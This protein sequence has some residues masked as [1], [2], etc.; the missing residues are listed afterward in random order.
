[1]RLRGDGTLKGVLWVLAEGADPYTGE[2]WPSYQTIADDAE[3]HRDTA[4]R[5]VK[6]AV[7][8]GLVTVLEQDFRS[9]NL[10][11]VN[12]GAVPDWDALEPDPSE[13]N[14]S[15]ERLPQDG[16]PAAD[17][18]PAEPTATTPPA[19]PDTTGGAAPDTTGGAAAGYDPEIPK[20]IPREIPKETPSDA[21]L[22]KPA[23]ASAD[24]APSEPDKPRRW[25]G[26]G[27]VVVE[28]PLAQTSDPTFRVRQS[29]VAEYAKDFP[30]LDI[31][32]ELRAIR[33]WNEENPRKRKTREGIRRHITT[34]LTTAQND[35]RKRASA[36]AGTPRTA[37]EAERKVSTCTRCGVVL[38]LVHGSWCCPVD[39]RERIEK[40][41]DRAAQRAK[42]V[43]VG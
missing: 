39:D 42:L 14:G 13:K 3:C 33:R 43:G 16:T 1:M 21:T 2:T 17:A 27:A 38:K 20:E 24:A 8:L 37:A 28:I 7:A 31:V 6:K 10:Y 34:W 36:R 5:K 25:E 35:P 23:P 32:A 19:A 26:N 41:N 12:V 30:A 22:A 9:S 4:I 40:L 15:T 11:R 18:A 29:L